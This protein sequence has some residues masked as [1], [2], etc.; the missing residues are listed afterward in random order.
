[1]IDHSGLPETYEQ[2]GRADSVHPL[3]MD[4]FPVADSVSD[5]PG[6]SGQMIPWNE[7]C[8]CKN[9]RC[10]FVIYRRTGVDQAVREF[11]GK[12]KSAPLKRKFPIY[13]NHRGLLFMALPL[14][15][16]GQSRYAF[17]QIDYQ[18]LDSMIFE[19]GGHIRDGIDTEPPFST[20]VFGNDLALILFPQKAIS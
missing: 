18:D 12:S 4:Q 15:Q 5:S 20:Y 17:R 7:K 9:I 8:S 13:D 11:V 6:F 2:H 16:A 1:M 3:E 14:N 19:Q 10:F